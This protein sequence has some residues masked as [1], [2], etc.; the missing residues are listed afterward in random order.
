MD[1]AEILAHLPNRQA[2]VQLDPADYDGWVYVF[3]DTPGD[4]LFTGYVSA[5][6]L[7]PVEVDLVAPVADD[8]VETKVEE[9]SAAPV[10]TAPQDTPVVEEGPAQPASSP[11]LTTDPKLIRLSENFTLW[12][13]IR[14]DS[15]DRAGL[16]NS[17]SLQEL[18]I[19]RETAKNMQ[20][21]RELLGSK[22]INVTS[23]FRNQ[24]V[25]EEVGGV[26][27]SAHRLGYAVDFT[28]PNFG[29][30]YDICKRIEDSPLIGIVDQL[31]QEYNAWVHISFD[32]R[33][34]G[35]KLS[36]FKV[37]GRTQIYAGFWETAEIAAANA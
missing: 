16:D 21:V 19:L 26:A 13:L 3:A 23:G 29:S 15:A 18:E 12:E 28:C 14:S 36:Y 1:G 2:V 25:N 33:V 17:P 24:A 20:L 37:D 34:R 27:N 10:D 8:E 32:P 31:I 30:P 4:G 6:H 9:M 7:G 5:A 35:E 11:V 22:P